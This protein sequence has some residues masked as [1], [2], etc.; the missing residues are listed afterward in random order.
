MNIVPL[1][2]QA[3]AQ[4]IAA[5]KANHLV[6]LLADRDITGDGV[7]VD[8]FGEQTTIPAGPVTIAMRTGTPLLPAAVYFTEDSHR[9]DIHGPM[10]LTRQG[11]FRSDMKRLT[12]DLAFELEALIRVAP[13][14]W[15][16]QQPNWPSDYDALEAIGHPHARPGHATI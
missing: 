4:V 16:L 12:Q 2:P 11:G 15:H 7:V 3:G 5:L 1:G 13:Q 14:Q 8:F 10:D 6:C 9:A